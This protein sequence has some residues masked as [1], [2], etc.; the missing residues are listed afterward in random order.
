MYWRDKDTNCLICDVRSD[1]S[2]LPTSQQAGV[3]QGEDNVS[4]LPCAKGEK[5][6]CIGESSL[7]ILNSNDVWTEV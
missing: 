6:F 2:N 5:C 1:I 3:Q 7:F 4:Y